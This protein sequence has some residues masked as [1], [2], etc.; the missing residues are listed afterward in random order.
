MDTRDT[1]PG[2]PLEG[3]ALTRRPHIQDSANLTWSPISGLSVGASAM[4][5]G[6]RVDQYDS[7]TAPP[8]VFLDKAYTVANLFGQYRLTENFSVF[9]R[10]ENLFNTHYE[11]ELGYGADGRAF[12]GG[13]RVTY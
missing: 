7:S 8:T 10:V 9:G 13:V 3:L 12:F 4:H 2:D 11:P 1:T 5:E 6:S